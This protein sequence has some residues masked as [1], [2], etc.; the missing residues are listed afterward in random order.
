MQ[1]YA[2]G[3][4]DG[5]ITYNIRSKI[6][7]TKDF[8]IAC[9]RESASYHTLAQNLGI[10][11]WFERT[12]YLEDGVMQ[13]ARI[14]K[15]AFNSQITIKF[16]GNGSYTY[17]FPYGTDLASLGGSYNV[18][19]LLSIAMVQAPDKE[20][21]EVVTLPSEGVFRPK[22]PVTVTTQAPLDAQYRLD[23]LQTEQILKNLQIKVQ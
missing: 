22:K 17:T 7:L 11:K 2:K 19:E 6:L 10:Q 20:S 8:P 12:V 5:S 16:S 4:R 3:H 1:V 14:D 9:D 21:V 13:V 15:P 23:Q 18:D